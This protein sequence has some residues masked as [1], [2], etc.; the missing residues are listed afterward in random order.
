MDGNGGR[1]KGNR[2][3]KISDVRRSKRSGESC[4]GVGDLFTPGVAVPCRFDA[5]NGREKTLA[6]SCTC[7]HCRGNVSFR[8]SEFPAWRAHPGNTF[9]PVSSPPIRVPLVFLSRGSPTRLD[10]TQSKPLSL[11]PG[12]ACIIVAL[13]G[14][15]PLSPIG[16]WLFGNLHKREVFREDSGILNV[17]L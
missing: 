2:R 5:F 6:S 10:S 13:T 3:G 4:P 11:W 12:R 7:L 17:R 8:S 14:S 15:I 9:N 1:Q 16:T